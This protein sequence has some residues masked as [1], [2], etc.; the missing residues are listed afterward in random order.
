MNLLSSLI[1]R[2]N[3]Q[4]NLL[5]R[6]ENTK[7]V[8]QAWDSKDKLLEAKKSGLVGIE[9]HGTRPNWAH[10]LAIGNWSASCQVIESWET[11]EKVMDIATKHVEDNPTD[12]F[13]YTLLSEDDFN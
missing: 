4:D 2:D 13:A 11:K 3:D 10:G 8:W 1:W 9:L 6:I 12:T 7:G 5:P